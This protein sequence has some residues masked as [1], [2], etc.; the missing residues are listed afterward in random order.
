LIS[1]ADVNTSRSRIPPRQ[2]GVFYRIVDT[3]N[4]HVGDLGMR[5]EDTLELGRGNCGIRLVT[6]RLEARSKEQTLEALVLDELLFSINNP[7]I[8]FCVDYGDVTGL[9]PSVWGDAVACGGS[10]VQVSLHVKSD[11]H[12]RG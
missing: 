8:A 11:G 6:S 7:I 5:Q 9:E 4:S 12:E 1:K 10:V 3:D 2:L